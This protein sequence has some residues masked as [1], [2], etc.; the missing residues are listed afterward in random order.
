MAR[1]RLPRMSLF[2]HLTE[3]LI[4]AAQERGEF[5][6]LPGAGRPIPDL[7]APWDELWWV[8]KWMQ[9]E[10]LRPAEELRA[11]LGSTGRAGALGVARDRNPDR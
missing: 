7:D 11:E 10:N 4:R 3:Q 5:D 2:P 9:R 1:A 6:G 8:R